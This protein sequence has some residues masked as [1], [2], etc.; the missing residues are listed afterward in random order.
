[1]ISILYKQID[2]QISNAQTILLLTDERID[3]DTIGAT[4]GMYHILKAMKKDVLVFS[5]RE[6]PETFSFLPGIECIGRDQDV[7]KNKDIDLVMIFDCADGAYVQPLLPT[8]ARKVPLIVV[9][10]H[11]T[12]PK[13]GFINLIEPDSA[14]ASGV[15]WRFVKTMNYPINKNSAQCILTG[16]CTD[17]DMFLTT[18]TNAACL[19]AAHELSRYGARLQEVVRETMMN[20]SVSAL[21][22]WGLAFERLHHNDEFNAIATAI[23][24][25][26]LQDLGATQEDLSG[27]IN[28][29][30][31]MI[32]GADTVLVYYERE[33]GSVKGSLR[34]QTVD[35]SV[36]AQKYAGG[37]HIRASGFQIHNSVLEEKDGKWFVQNRS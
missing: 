22:L 32:E 13:Y 20:K 28:F 15:V 8:M 9:D 16:I 4:L 12:N 6:I 37:G 24:L 19:D 17:T 5:P 26:D 7:F 2:E 36:L 23:T 30:N 29:L 3:G 33:D 31:S 18:S 11:I 35:V 25:K 34:S 21:R 27:L 10:H 14:S 1:M